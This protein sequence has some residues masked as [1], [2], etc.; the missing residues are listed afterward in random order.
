[1]QKIFLR[2]VQVVSNKTSR[3][4]EDDQGRFEK[5]EIADLTRKIEESQK[6]ENREGERGRSGERREIDLLN[7]TRH[8]NQR[9]RLGS[10]MKD[11]EQRGE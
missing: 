6:K 2:S 4:S 1:V 3:T 8:D 7:C 9:V 11:A 10:I 5:R